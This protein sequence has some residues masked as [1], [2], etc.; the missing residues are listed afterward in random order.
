MKKMV[1]LSGGL[2][3]TILLY[4]MINELGID[5]NDI[6]ALS[7]KLSDKKDFIINN[8]PNKLLYQNNMVELDFAQKTTKTLNIKHVIVDVTYMNNILD[9]MRKSEKHDLNST[10]K[11]KQTTSMPFRNMILMSNAFAFAQMNE[12]DEIYV[13]YQ[14]Q[15]QYGYWDTNMEFVNKLNSIAA[16]NPDAKNVKIVCPFV[17]LSKSDEILIGLKHNV[18]FENTWTCYNPVFQNDELKQCGKCLSCKERLHCFE[19]VNIKDPQKYYE[20]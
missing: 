5:K 2:D 13:G 1:I 6:I 19:K 14:K 15:D 12:C 8:D 10:N 9:F 7:F 20:R 18:P 3:S 16:L 17:E 4:Y 11:N